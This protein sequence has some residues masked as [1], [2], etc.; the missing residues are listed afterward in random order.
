MRRTTWIIAT[1]IPF[2]I[3]S[4]SLID[5]QEPPPDTFI[6]WGPSGLELDNYITQTF[7]ARHPELEIIITDQG[8]DE[9]LRQNLQNAMLMQ[10]PPDVVI[11][12]NYFRAFAAEGALLP[13]NDIIARYVDDIVPATYAA[14]LYD[15]SVYAIPMLTGVFAFERNCLVV[16]MAGLNC[17][18]PPQYWD[19]LLT[20]AEAITD[21]GRGHAYGYTLQGPGGTAVGSAFRIAVYQAQLDAL[22]CADEGCTVPTFNNPNVIPVYEMLR[23]LV[24]YTPPGLLDNTNEGQVYEALF[25]GVS[26]FQIAGSWH[27]GWAETAGCDTCRYSPVPIPRDGHPANLLVGNVL[28]AAPSMGRHPDMAKEWLELLIS[29]EAQERV[30]SQLGRL[31]VRISVLNSIRET[32]D[33]ATATFIDELLYNDS[34]TLLPQWESNPRETWAIYNDLLT[35]VL[36]TDQPIPEIMQE[37]QNA[38]EALSGT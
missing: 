15:G 32:V 2:F 14:A 33:P 17:D 18:D 27:V 6:V 13:L 26:A 34:L 28:Y 24:T 31:P 22:P 29:T 25:R 12:E 23:Q 38:L 3:L 35:A 16:E 1:L 4:G 7:Q 10:S 20:E 8:W 5:A 21:A 19:E 36:K 11:G 9:A 37:A 30:F